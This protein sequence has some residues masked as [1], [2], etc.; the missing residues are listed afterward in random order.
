MALVDSGKT[1]LYSRRPASRDDLEKRAEIEARAA[2]QRAVHVLQRHQLPDVVG[3]DAATIQ[4]VAEFGGLRSKPLAQPLP[5]VRVRLRG[6]RRRRVAAGADG[7]DRL[8][9]DD[10]QPD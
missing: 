7:P 1:L 3:L 9:G 10:Q 5:D 4:D 2:D 8:V 6:L